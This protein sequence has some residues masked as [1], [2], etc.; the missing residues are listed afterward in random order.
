MFNT[1]WQKVQPTEAGKAFLAAGGF[2]TLYEKELAQKRQDDFL[3]LQCKFMNFQRE[4]LEDQHRHNI[5]QSKKMLLVARWTAFAT[6][7]SGAASD[8]MIRLAYGTYMNEHEIEKRPM[9]KYIQDL[10]K[11]ALGYKLAGIKLRK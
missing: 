4:M 7:L 5:E 10:R 3:E 2:A 9:S 11:Q 1:S 8:Y 6:F